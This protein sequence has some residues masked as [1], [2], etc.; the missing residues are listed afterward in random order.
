MKDQVDIEK[1]LSYVIPWCKCKILARVKK[2]AKSFD[3]HEKRLHEGSNLFGFSERIEPKLEAESQA[4][5]G[6]LLEP[7]VPLSKIGDYFLRHVAQQSKVS[8]TEEIMSVLVTAWK[9]ATKVP[10]L[11]NSL[12]GLRFGG[13]GLPVD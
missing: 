8:S 4:R 1:L 7:N 11:K 6:G 9:L 2:L 10:N 5:K 12:D 13:C 3:M